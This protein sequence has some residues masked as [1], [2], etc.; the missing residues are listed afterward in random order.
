MMSGQTMIFQRE[1]YPDANF[2]ASKGFIQRFSERHNLKCIT[3]HGE[4]QSADTDAVEPFL[5]EMAEIQKEYSLDQI[6]NADESGLIYKSLPNT[7]LATFEERRTNSASNTKHEKERI[8]FLSCT[9]ASA[10][11]VLPLVF[12]HKVKNPRCFQTVGVDKITKK[13][14]P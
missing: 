10:S 2:D 3:L 12:I 9:N 8:T 14:K 13:R 11:H 1:F 4:K 7:T 6:Y 5:A